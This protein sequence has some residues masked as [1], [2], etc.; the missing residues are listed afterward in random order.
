MNLGILFWFY[1]D[2]P[3][4]RN[5]LRYYRKRNPGVPIYGLYS[6]E[7]EQA[8]EFKAA[9]G[10]L[11]DDF[12]AFDQPRSDYW[13]WANG[14]LVIA[15]WYRNRGHALEWDTVFLAAWDV[16]AAAPVRELFRDLPPDHLLLSNVRPV[17]DVEA[18]W[19]WVNRK[20]E[21]FDAF[22][23]EVRRRH[24]EAVE[25]YCCQFI[26]VCLP[27]VFLEKFAAA[28]APEKGFVE[29][30]VPTYAKL[31]GVPFHCDPGFDAVWPGEPGE[32]GDAAPEELLNPGI[33]EVPMRA[34][35]RELLRPGGRRLFHP[36]E[37]TWP[38]GP[39]SAWAWARDVL[40]GRRGRRP[41]REQPRPHLM[42]QNADNG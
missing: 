20:R 11:L 40:T 36:V 18:W 12:Y 23:D 10:P 35:A 22:M 14:D 8:G 34:I 3:L 25:A 28:D 42:N 26:I 31:L 39:A 32:S 17:R 33:R 27:R 37:R 2:A 30:R 13:R 16:L 1:K 9:L 6:G 38:T 24:G 19:R 21:R 29:Y 4:C 5:H 7:P 15:D 41:H